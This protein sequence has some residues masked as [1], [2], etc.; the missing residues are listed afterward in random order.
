MHEVIDNF[1]EENYFRQIQKIFI[2]QPSPIPWFYI[3]KM[4]YNHTDNDYDCMFE[5]LVYENVKNSELYE[6]FTPLY[7][8]LDIKSL[9]RIKFNLYPHKDSLVVHSKHKDYDFR[10]KGAIISINTCDG[11]TLLSDGSKIKSVENRIL[12]FDPSTEHA[13]TNTTNAKARFNINV[14]YF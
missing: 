7:D 4:N 3:H 13:S 8:L 14:N 1:F 5:H 11:F 12:L 9:I 10:H 2:E 6:L